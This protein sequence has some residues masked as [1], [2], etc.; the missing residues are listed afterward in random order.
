MVLS[1]RLLE[2]ANIIEQNSSVIDIGCD[3]G[4]LDIYL[5]MHKQCKCKAV[6]VSIKCVE[7][8]IENVN[9]YGVSD[10]VE[11]I[12]SDGFEKVDVGADDVIVISGMGTKTILNILKGLNSGNRLIISSHNDL[13]ILRNEICGI[14]YYIFDE[15]V[16]NDK[17]INYVIIDFRKGKRKYNFVEY[18]YGPILMKNPKYFFYFNDIVKKNEYILR[19]IPNKH[20]KKKLLMLIEN[21][22][23]KKIT[24]KK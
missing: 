6:D 14:G 22:Y 16:V 13:D 8:A 17:N 23:L 12:L 19:K 11:V 3:H 20:I 9:K 2:I 24:S 18:K 21:C 10:S 15:K 7:K 5:A 1:K 4:F